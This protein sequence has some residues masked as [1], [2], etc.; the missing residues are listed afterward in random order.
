MVY[1]LN[2][3]HVDLGYIPCRIF[4]NISYGA[5]PGTH[6]KFIRDFFGD[7][8]LPYSDNTYDLFRVNEEFIKD[9]KNIEVSKWLMN[10]VKENHT[11]VNRI[12]T[13]LKFI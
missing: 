13:L 7:N 10:E 2:Q 5:I 4:K 9:D 8:I 11:Y 6:S 12:K 3:L 1:I